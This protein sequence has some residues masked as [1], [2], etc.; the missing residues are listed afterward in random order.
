[1]T[2]NYP[3]PSSKI[4]RKQEKR[5]LTSDCTVQE[6]QQEDCGYLPEK[7]KKKIGQ[8]QLNLQCQ[9]ICLVR[10]SVDL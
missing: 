3:T 1:M 10:T 6:D 4:P 9:V 5:L 8:G 7:K 2:T